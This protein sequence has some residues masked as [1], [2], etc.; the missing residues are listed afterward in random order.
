MKRS[1]FYDVYVLASLF[2]AFLIII[3]VQINNIIF[4]QPVPEIRFQFGQTIVT[5]ADINNDIY[6]RELENQN[7]IIQFDP[8]P[9]WTLTFASG[10]QDIILR[11]SDFAV[12]QYQTYSDRLVL[13][14]TGQTIVPQYTPISV[15]VEI[16]LG[17][18]LQNDEGVGFT[19][20]VDNEAQQAL[21]NVAFPNMKIKPIGDSS[22]NV[23]FDPVGAGVLRRPFV[24]APATIVRGNPSTESSM[25]FISMYNYDLNKQLYFQTLDSEGYSKDFVTAADNNGVVLGVAQY[26]ENNVIPRLDYSQPYG[27]E[28]AVI[29]GNWYDAAKKYRVWAL[30][31]PWASRGKI[32][33][34]PDFSQTLKDMRL[35]T[36][37]NPS[38]V[39]QFPIP[40][41]EFQKMMDEAIRVKNFFGLANGMSMVHWYGWHNNQMDVE[42]PTSTTPLSGVTPALTATRAAGIIVMPYTLI[43][44]W[45]LGSPAYIS[46]NVEPLTARDRYGQQ[47]TSSSSSG[48]YLHADIDPSIQQARDLMRN[49][50]LAAITV[51]FI[52]GVYFDVW[53]YFLNIR[54]YR[55][56]HGHQPGGGNYW[57]K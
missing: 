45:T 2:L 30:Q 24:D 51:G 29:R 42:F 37:Q 21:Y 23:L 57:A 31:Q 22:K 10:T 27:I 12:F 4:L 48:Q 32:E 39:G 20:Q 47:I 41:G 16:K 44:S 33:T 46:N 7:G 53:S 25:Q 36:L 19:I 18:Q 5:L 43:N 40:S 28:M 26:P 1:S 9:L 6:L 13:S 8:M 35:Y 14:W 15:T 55:S 56:T 54:D 11:P 17:A 52:D 50:F 3:L 34:A 38:G 49:R